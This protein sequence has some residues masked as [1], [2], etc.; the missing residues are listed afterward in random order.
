MV[1]LFDRASGTLARLDLSSVGPNV[2]ARY[3]IL[4]PENQVAIG[5]F[6]A[7]QLIDRDTLAFNARIPMRP[8]GYGGDISWSSNYK[9]ASRGIYGGHGGL[10]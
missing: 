2:N 7:A 9:Y 4:A 1:T 10:C 3:A 5:S 6:G 8:D